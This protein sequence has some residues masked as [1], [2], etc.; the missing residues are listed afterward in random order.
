MLR[1]ELEQWASL[2][3][4]AEAARASVRKT[5][6]L[7]HAIVHANSQE[8]QRRVWRNLENTP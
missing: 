5:L 4:R 7:T 2:I 3:D 8:E 1:G 6:R